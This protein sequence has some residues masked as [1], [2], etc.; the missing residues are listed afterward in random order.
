MRQRFAGALLALGRSLTDGLLPPVCNNC[1]D[2]VATAGALCSACWTRIT[3][4]TDPLCPVCGRPFDHDLGLGNT[5]CGACAAR[6]PAFDRARAAIVYD[7][8]SR[9]VITG[10]KYADR[11]LLA[12]VLGRW[13]A[14]AGAGLLS[15]A[16][17]LVPIPLHRWRLFTRRYN[18]S[19]LLAKVIAEQSGV[20]VVVDQLIRVRHTPSQSSR[21]RRGRLRNM[22]GA[23]AVNPR[24]PSLIGRRLIIIDD[25][26]TTGATIGEGARVLRLAGA[27]RVDALTLAR[28]P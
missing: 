14:R 4:I 24:A 6:V 19:V 25:V 21:S 8:G 10:F 9:G 2:V 27:A 13:M 7:D 15:T 3:F 28:V 5:I 20:P 16:D 12:P 26:M 18:Q 23:F 17:A 1:R 22:Q 11:T